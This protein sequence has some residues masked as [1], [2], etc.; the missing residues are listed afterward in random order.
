MPTR[1]DYINGDVCRVMTGYPEDRTTTEA[2]RY[3]SSHSSLGA[4]LLATSEKGVVTVLL[5]A[6]AVPLTKLLLERFPLADVRPG[7]WSEDELAMRVVHFIERPSRGLNVPLDLRGTRFQHRVWEIIRD[8]PVGETST[9]SAIA[10]Q[11]GAPSDESA[12]GLACAANELALVVP[13]H[14][15]VDD[16][17]RTGSRYR[18]GRARQTALLAREKASFAANAAD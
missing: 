17:A 13:C 7:H 2:I 5:G 11:I 16:N 9:Y 4:L 12:V 1:P 6:D 3:V 8:I 10:R 15:V 18:W 14:R